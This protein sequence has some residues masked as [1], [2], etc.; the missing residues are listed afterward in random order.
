MQFSSFPKSKEGDV[1]SFY[2]ILKKLGEGSYGKIYKVKNK[3]TEE[4]RAMKQMDKIKIQQNLELFKN[5]IEIMSILD[6]PNICKLFEVY[7]DSKFFYLIIEYCEGGELLDRIT[8]K[9]KE[10]KCYTEKEAAVIFK[11]LIEAIEY[12]HEIGVIHRDLKPE[13][14]LFS[15]KYEN[16][17]IKIIDFGISKNLSKLDPNKKIKL[18]SKVGTVYYMSPE[19]IKGSYTELC[20]V[21]AC[22]IILYI[23]LCGYPPFSGAN[24]KEI[25]N[26]IKECKLEFPQNEWKKISKNAKELIKKIIC[27]EK[28][29]IDASQIL[30]DKWFKNKTFESSINVKGILNLNNL[31]FQEKITNKIKKKVYNFLISNLNENEIKNDKKIFQS[32]DNKNK[33]F[34][35]FDELKVAFEENKINKN[36]YIQI[37]DFFKNNNTENDGKIYFNE[38]LG[39]IMD[40]TLLQKEG[41]LIEAFKV[42]DPLNLGKI[43]V[44][45]FKEILNVNDDDIKSDDMLKQFI[46]TNEKTKENNIDYIQFVKIVF[47]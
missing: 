31:Y 23:L 35:T 24:D 11:Q 21:W 22:G 34:I 9:Q 17:P 29:R 47:Q 37:I 2:E 38:F 33:N 32:I 16:S 19:I 30:R 39:G 42:Y 8:K 36:Q 25:Y 44:K 12:I 43:P 7:E 28:N 20:D 40:L 13:N 1:M 4:I 41:K 26:R 15:T 3:D 46:K 5:E 45:K 14:I 6:H 27:P 10:G 18:S